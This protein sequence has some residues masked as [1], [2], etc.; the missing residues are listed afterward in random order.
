MTEDKEILKKI[1]H[2]KEVYNRYTKEIKKLQLRQEEIVL[3]YIKKREME[4]IK[5]IQ[6]KIKN[7]Y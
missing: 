4:E 3:N 2:I 5:R 6:E 7:N 1:D